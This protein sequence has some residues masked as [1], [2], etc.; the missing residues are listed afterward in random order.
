MACV[1]GKSLICNLRAFITSR[2]SPN[3]VSMDSARTDCI[4]GCLVR[5]L[6]RAGWLCKS[7]DDSDDIQ[8]IYQRLSNTNSAFAT[9]QGIHTDPA[10]YKAFRNDTSKWLSDPVW[11]ELSNNLVF[12]HLVQSYEFIAK[13]LME[14]LDCGRLSLKRPPTAFE[15]LQKLGKSVEWGE[16][17]ALLNNDLRNAMAHGR[18]WIAKGAPDWK[19]AYAG[20][21]DGG[22]TL[23]D[24]S[25]EFNRIHQVLLSLYTW[26]AEWLHAGPGR[27]PVQA[28]RADYPSRLSRGPRP[29]RTPRPRSSGSPSRCR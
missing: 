6:G 16:F 10:T 8:K 13:M 21:P 5:D 19:L 1:H 15:I 24:L 20:A 18:Y 26:Y 12:Y 7:P 2:R 11:A 23:W 28:A 3:A 27:D 14:I 17:A 25:V 22:F 29:A 9:V 4:T